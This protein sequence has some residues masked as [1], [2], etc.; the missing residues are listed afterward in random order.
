MKK[1]IMAGVITAATLAALMGAPANA[2]PLSSG[3]SGISIP[4]IQ[5]PPLPKFELPN[6]PGSSL[7]APLPQGNPTTRTV[8]IDGV[9]LTPDEA[10]VVRLVNDHRIRHGLHP[11]RVDQ[12]L[13][14]RAREWSNIQAQQRHLHHSPDNVFENIAMNWEGIPTVFNQWLKSP[15]HNANMLEPTVTR[16]GVSAAQGTD[17]AFYATM[18]LIW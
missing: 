15:S 7:P 3:S 16:F 18:Q 2:T 4:N 17:G 14:N 9:M 1:K 10:T 12:R 13:T 11:L 6:L 5:L 8:N